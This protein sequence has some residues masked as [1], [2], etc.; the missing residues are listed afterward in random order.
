MRLAPGCARCRILGDLDDESL[1]ALTSEW[2]DAGSAEAFF[3]SREFQIFGG[4]HIL[5]RDEP[6]IILDDVR[7]RVTRP[8]RRH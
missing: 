7:A 5:L 4:I 6:V 8:V 2:E 1:V 3:D